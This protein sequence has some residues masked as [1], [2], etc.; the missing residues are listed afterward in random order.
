[1]KNLPIVLNIVLLLAVGYLYYSDFSTKRK[2]NAITSAGMATIQNDSTG[3]RSRIAY[4]EL[5]SLNE[6]IL[7]F[8][9]RKKE[10][11]E[12]QKN[13]ETGLS[14]EYNALTDKKND[15]YKKNPNANPE[16]VQ[17]LMLQLGREQQEIENK[18]QAE[19]QMLQQKSFK[20][21][22]LVQKNLKEF[23]NDYNKE[24]KFQYILSA[25]GG[26]D[27]LIYKDSA[28]DITRDVIM[29]MN[30]KLKGQPKQ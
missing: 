14:N 8:K 16:D 27:W 1:M 9:Q 20:L 5:D 30:E 28:L 12:E 22:E 19:S 2:V 26:I 15:F 24:K 7:Y 17:N 29:G 3:S 4:V 11:E 18:K 6:N 23:L 21:M 13:I 25:G 10:L